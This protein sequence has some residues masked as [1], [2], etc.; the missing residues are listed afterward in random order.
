[1]CTSVVF[2]RIFEKSV[3]LFLESKMPE[4]CVNDNGDNDSAA[5]DL[6]E[7]MR[8]EQEYVTSLKPWN[9]SSVDYSIFGNALT[10]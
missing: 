10:L 9:Y 8:C 2:L 4:G 6:V 3:T 7:V 1:M 5:I